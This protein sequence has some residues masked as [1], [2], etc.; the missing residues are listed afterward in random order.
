MA[1]ASLRPDSVRANPTIQSPNLRIAISAALR[2]HSIPPTRFG[3]DAV[4]DPAFYR[5]VMHRGRELRPVT[6]SRVRAYLAA[7]DG[8]AS[9]G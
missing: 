4:N 3:R 7:L 1:E 2:R 5:D 6:E 9:H 8:E